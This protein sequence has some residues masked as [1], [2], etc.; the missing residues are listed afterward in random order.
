MLNEYHHSNELCI[1]KF[2]DYV[3][4]CMFNT[5]YLV[6]ALNFKFVSLCN[7]KQ[8]NHCSTPE[9]KFRSLLHY[10]KKLSIDQA[11]TRSVSVNACMSNHIYLQEWPVWS[12]SCSSEVTPGSR[13]MSYRLLLVLLTVLPY[14]RTGSF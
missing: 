13:N 11:I 8:P 6:T 5:L 2:Y 7:N 3:Y 14:F 10:V 12:A 1:W 4:H 9:P